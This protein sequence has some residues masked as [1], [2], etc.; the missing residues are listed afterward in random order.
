MKNVIALSFILASFH[1]DSF[2]DDVFLRNGQVIKNCKVLDTVET[3]VR[4]YTTQRERIIPLV[5]IVS[6]I[7]APFDSTKE[8]E[9]VTFGVLPEPSTNASLITYNYPNIL[10]LPVSAVALVLAW[11]YFAQASDLTDA[12]NGPYPIW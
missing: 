12:I 4:V 10:L 3:R 2:A 8:S 5:S 9:V 6:I 1:S 7:I 11:D